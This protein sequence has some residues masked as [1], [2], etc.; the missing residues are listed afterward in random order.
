M[1]FVIQYITDEER[2][3]SLED[4]CIWLSFS[5]PSYPSER[6]TPSKERKCFRVKTSVALFL[7]DSL[8]AGEAEE[9]EWGMAD[10]DSSLR[11]LFI[12]LKY[13]KLPFLL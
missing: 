12:Y 7:P 13:F 9:E 5:K 1:K 3:F 8:P 2:L 11:I 4:S 6:L 10:S